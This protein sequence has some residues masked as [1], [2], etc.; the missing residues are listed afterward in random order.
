MIAIQNTWII[1]TTID[2]RIFLV[3]FP[4]TF[5]ILV[6]SF[7]VPFNLGSF[8]LLVPSVLNHFLT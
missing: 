5:S 3:I 4:K 2:T 1:F 8:I 6:A 7:S